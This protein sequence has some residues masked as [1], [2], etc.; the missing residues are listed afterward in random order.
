VACMGHISVMQWALEAGEGW[1]LS[2]FFMGSVVVHLRP[3]LHVLGLKNPVSG[4]RCLI[5][6]LT[7]SDFRRKSC[8]KELEAATKQPRG[9]TMMAMTYQ[10]QV[11]NQ[12]HPTLDST[13]KL[14][15]P[16]RGLRHISV[17]RWALEAGEGCFLNQFLMGSVVVLVFS[18][19]HSHVLGVN[20][21]VSGFR[22]VIHWLTHP[23]FQRKSCDKGLGAVSNQPP[24]STLMAMTYQDQVL[25]KGAGKMTP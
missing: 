20:T 18:R 5:L 7:H 23:D 9:A 3:H 19:P 8:D 16:G 24:G 11:L 17:K 13:S 14:T 10:D 6:W 25:N 15:H 4:S 22:C 12:H 21:A 1:F 2:Q